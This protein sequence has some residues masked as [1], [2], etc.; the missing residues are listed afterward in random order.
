M[1]TEP[2]QSDREK[3]PNKEVGQVNWSRKGWIFGREVEQGEVRGEK[4]RNEEEKPWFVQSIHHV[5]GAQESRRRRSG[6]QEHRDFEGRHVERCLVGGDETG[7]ED[8]GQGLTRPST[9]EM[10]VE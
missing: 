3:S 7:I 8:E 10:D 4:G 5:V 1:G 9:V 6:V 2:S